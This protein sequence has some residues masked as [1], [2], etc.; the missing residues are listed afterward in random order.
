MLRLCA[1]PRGGN[2]VL[3]ANDIRQ[4]GGIGAV[5]LCPV[6]PLFSAHAR[7]RRRDS[8]GGRRLRVAREVSREGGNAAEPLPFKLERGAPGGSCACPSGTG[9]GIPLSMSGLA[10]GQI[11]GS[12]PLHRNVLPTL[13]GLTLTHRGKRRCDDLGRR[14]V[15]PADRSA[16]LFGMCVWGTLLS[17]S[18]P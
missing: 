13:N 5:P 10:S 1:P 2:N 7:V 6:S 9:S 12:E 8:L 15:D 17:S 4:S 3:A 18:S 14:G 11:A 16:R